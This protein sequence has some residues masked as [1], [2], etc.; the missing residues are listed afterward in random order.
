MNQYILIVDDT[1]SLAFFLKNALRGDVI[2][3]IAITFIY[4]CICF[5]CYKDHKKIMS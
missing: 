4:K 5:L 2:M 3:T 1:E